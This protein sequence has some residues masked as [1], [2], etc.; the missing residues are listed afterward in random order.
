MLR[1]H[2]DAAR[3]L[4]QAVDDPGADELG[5]PLLHG[6][7]VAGEEEV[8]HRARV[9]PGG[10]VG[11]EA[12]GLVQGQDVLVL[13]EDGNGQVLGEDHG[14]LL[15]GLH[16]HLLPFEPVGG[17]ED[18]PVP[19]PDPPGLDPGLGLGPA[20]GEGLRHRLVQTHPFP[21]KA[22][23]ESPFYPLRGRVFSGVFQKL[24]SSPGKTP[25]R[26]SCAYR[27]KASWMSLPASR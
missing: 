18:H 10:G 25:S 12:R 14:S 6:P 26:T 15:H 5:G 1:H 7:V 23:H 11:K 20:H 16:R 4:V 21:T 3:V 13:V 24:C 2:Q 17:L 9:D 8:H 27:L 19:H 22:H